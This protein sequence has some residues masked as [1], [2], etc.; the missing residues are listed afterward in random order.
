MQAASSSEMLE[1]MYTA[2]CSNP[3]DHN[4]IKN[5]VYSSNPHTTKKLKRYDHGKIFHTFQEIE[6]IKSI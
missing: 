2:W 5:K 6:N 4:V 3:E 1:Q